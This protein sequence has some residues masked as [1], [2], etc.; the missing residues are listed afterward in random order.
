MK[1][2]IERVLKENFANLGPVISVDA[3]AS[4][5]DTADTGLTMGM[6]EKALEKV[7]PAIKGLGGSVEICA[8]DSASGLVRLRYT[9]PPRLKLGIE[10][11]LKDV[12]M[13][14]LVQIDV[15]DSVA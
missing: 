5:S 3:N 1:M 14:K 9:G 13:V 11:V 7:L 6:V 12:A 15:A 2:G 4:A 10:L 8:I